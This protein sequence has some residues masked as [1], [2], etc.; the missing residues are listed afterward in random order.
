MA[1]QPSKFA[2]A[3]DLVPVAAVLPEERAD[4]GAMLIMRDGSFRLIVR[5]GAVNFDMKSPPE[6]AGITYAFGS[7]VNSLDVESPI[8][9]VAHSKRLDV[10]AYSRQY[11]SRLANE[12]TPSQIRRLIQAHVEHFEEHVKTNNLLQREFYIVLPWKGVS[13]PMVPGFTDNIPLAPLFKRVFANIEKKASQ[14]HPSDQDISIARQQ[15]ELRAEQIAERMSQMGIWAERLNEEGVRKLL[16]ELYNPSLAERQSA[17]LGD[18]EGRLM[19]G[20]SAE[21]AP[22]GRRAITDNRVLEP[23]TFD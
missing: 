6:Q 21:R 11:A 19:P 16:Y 7:L 18:Y 12:R 20:F 23:P 22:Q 9:I 14:H 13:G 17:P 5:V 10:D 15:L 8:Q 4:A 2:P 3:V 1:D